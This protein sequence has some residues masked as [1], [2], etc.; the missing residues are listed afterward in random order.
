MTLRLDVRS[1]RGAHLHLPILDFATL[2]AVVRVHVTWQ[3]L[4][5]HGFPLLLI[6][7]LV[8]MRA[9]CS[10]RMIRIDEVRGDIPGFFAGEKD[11]GA[12]GTGPSAEHVDKSQEK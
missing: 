5:D 12:F 10:L 2:S 7:L 3:Q 4:L 1:L 8:V 6:V 11:L 9:A